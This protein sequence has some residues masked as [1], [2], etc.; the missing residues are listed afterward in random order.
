MNK[1]KYHHGKLKEAII[2]EV[3]KQ[4]RNSSFE[5]I[6][7]RSIARNIGVASSAPYNHFE[8]KEKLLENISQCISNCSLGKVDANTLPIFDMQYIW[9]Q[10]HILSETDPL[11]YNIMCSECEEFNTV[12]IDLNNFRM[13]L[14]EGH[15]NVIKITDDLKLVMRY[16]TASM[17]QE[18]QNNNMIDFFDIASLCI[19][20]VEYNGEMISDI[21][22]EEKESF[23]DNLT[24]K[25]FNK[26]SLFFATIPVV[27]NEIVF[28]CEKCETTNTNMMNGYMAFSE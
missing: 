22:L 5:N 11:Q 9:I 2:S 16:P 27:E 3:I 21:P 18:Q 10:L 8:S 24:K 1:H 14:V 7:F 20:Q 13:N 12:D 25:E 19:E 26:I 15:T 17:L 28:N 6:S 4:L 23:I